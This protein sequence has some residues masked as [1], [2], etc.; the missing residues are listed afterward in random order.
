[1]AR[2]DSDWSAARRGR[3]GP[4]SQWP[5]RSGSVETLR[6]Q[7]ASAGEGGK[8]AHVWRRVA[9]SQ[10]RSQELGKGGGRICGQRIAAYFCCT[11]CERVAAPSGRRPKQ[12]Q[13]AHV[14]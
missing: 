14:S 4:A 13:F 9:L 7:W 8:G 1:M 10:A 6:R 11:H 12:P 3:D 2:G 5:A